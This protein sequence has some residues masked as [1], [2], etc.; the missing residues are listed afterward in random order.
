VV[1]VPSVRSPHFLLYAATGWKRILKPSN[2]LTRTD[3]SYFSPATL[4]RLA[5]GL[6]FHRE[7]IAIGRWR[8]KYHGVLWIEALALDPILNATRVGGILYIGRKA[9]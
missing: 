4:N 9:P 3:V 7:R 8:P 6:G 1:E 5:S 2:G